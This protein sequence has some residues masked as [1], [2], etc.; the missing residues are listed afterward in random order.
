MDT[1]GVNQGTEL[2]CQ[3]SVF[4]ESEQLVGKVKVWSAQT[5]KANKGVSHNKG[6]YDVLHN[7]YSVT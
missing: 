7:G 1:Q 5:G 6:N 2:V 3:A 4:A